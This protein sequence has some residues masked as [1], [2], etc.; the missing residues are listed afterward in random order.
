MTEP[1]AGSD[2]RGMTTT[3]RRDG[4]DW[5]INGT[6]HFISGGDHADFFIVFVATGVDDTVWSKKRITCFLV[7]RG[8]PGFSVLPGY[9]LYRIV[10]ITM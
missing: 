5:V 7:D 10:A 6:K 1:D 3:A 2:V 9:Q 4:G 8:R